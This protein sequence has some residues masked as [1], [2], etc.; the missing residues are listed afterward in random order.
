VSNATVNYI[1]GMSWLAVL[2]VEE[3]GV[4]GQRTPEP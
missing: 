1:S 3:T 2:L 4:T